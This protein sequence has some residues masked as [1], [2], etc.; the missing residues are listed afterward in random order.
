MKKIVFLCDWGET[1]ESILKRYSKQTPNNSGIWVDLVGV[2]NIDEADYFIVLEGY[3]KQLPQE[4][5]IYIKR[6]PDF[7][8]TKKQN[9]NN[10]ILWEDTNCGVTWWLN[11]SY[12]ELKNLDYPT[13]NNKISCVTS[14]KHTHRNQMVKNLVKKIKEM[15][16]YGKGHDKNY[17]G[18]TYKGVLNYDGN[19]KFLGLIDYEYSIVLENSQQKNYW[20]EKLADAYLS[21][22]VPIYFGCPNIKDFFPE[23]SVYM[24]NNNTTIEDI[25]K[26]LSNDICL[27]DIKKSRDLIL[28][29]YNI[30]EVINKKLKTID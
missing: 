15:H 26:I 22:C 24:I 20:T 10:S 14:A 1:S 27:E 4:K 3:H 13:K 30:W 6:E 21:W 9:Y 18:E 5:T 8:S 29:E 16:L 11:K 7:I 2:K 12:D 19:C 25:D 23:N 17:Y 28:D